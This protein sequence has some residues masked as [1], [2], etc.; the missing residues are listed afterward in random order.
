[1][2]LLRERQRATGESVD[3][4]KAIGLTIERISEI[5]TSISAAVEQQAWRP[6]VSQKVSGPRRAARRKSL[7]KSS[8]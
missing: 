8:A 2:P 6:R 7:K 1:V 4:I 5:T 3:A